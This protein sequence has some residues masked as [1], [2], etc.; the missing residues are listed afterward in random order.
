MTIDLIIINLDRTLLLAKL[1][2][3]II[4][5][6][7]RRN[8]IELYRKHCCNDSLYTRALE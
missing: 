4:G 8:D 7:Q 5:I 3:L 1:R 6:P 2:H